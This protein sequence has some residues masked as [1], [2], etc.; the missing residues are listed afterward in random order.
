MVY[1][2]LLIDRQIKYFEKLLCQLSFQGH[3]DQ[4][5]HFG[6]CMH[7][8]QHKYISCCFFPSPERKEGGNGETEFFCENTLLH[9][10][11]TLTAL[12][13]S[14]LSVPLTA[15]MLSL[16]LLNLNASD[17]PV[18]VKTQYVT[19]GILQ[20]VR[21]SCLVAVK[22]RDGISGS[23]SSRGSYTVQPMYDSSPGGCQG[24]ICLHCDPF[25]NQVLSPDWPKESFES[26]ECDARTTLL[27]SNGLV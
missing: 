18:I 7:N 21:N 4:K 27:A 1:Y 24:F 8:R 5:V 15:H 10:C 20:L 3:T 14:L 6:P 16:F 19:T 13:S 12:L 26:P 11:W 17:K 22:D 9:Q 2:L 23:P 25:S